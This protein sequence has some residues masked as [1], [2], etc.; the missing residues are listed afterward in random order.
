MVSTLHLKDFEVSGIL[1]S[2]FTPAR[3]PITEV[4]TAGIERVRVLPGQLWRWINPNPF[5]ARS[6]GK[7]FIL[8]AKKIILVANASALAHACALAHAS[9]L[10]HATLREKM[11]SCHFDYY[12]SYV[13]FPY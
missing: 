2:S 12:Y 8:L 7:L 10:A 11:V 3:F 13:I 4:H 6:A 5:L 9:A 1:C